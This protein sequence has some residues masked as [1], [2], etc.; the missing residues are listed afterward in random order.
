MLRGTNQEFGRPYNRRIV[1]ETIRLKGPVSRADIAREVSLSAQT[2]SNIIRELEDGGF[3]KSRR[4]KPT[5]R[6]QP[7]TMLEIDG[8]GGYAI[9]LQL[10]P[11]HAGAIAVDLAGERVA[12]VE[13]RMPSDTQGVLSTAADLAGRMRAAC[14]SGRVLGLGVAMPGPFD[15]EPMSHA[16]STTIEALRGVPLRQTFAGLTGLPVFIG[17]D[18][19]AAA[20]GERQFGAGAG[21]SD[22]FYVFFSAGLGGATISDRALWSGSHGNAGELG[23]MMAVPDGD[24]CP[25][26]ARGCLERYVSLDALRRRFQAQGL[27]PEGVPFCGDG[28]GPLHPVVEAWIADAAP[29]LARA[30]AA[31]E[32]LLDPATIIVGGALPCAVLDRLL[33]AMEPLPPSV[34]QR[35]NRA[36]PRIMRS[37]LGSD[38]ALLG[39]A[40]LAFNGVLSPRFG[41]L[42]EGDAGSAPDPI[43]ARQTRAAPLL[44]TAARSA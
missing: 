17:M 4:E 8:R 2:V 29:I 28:G 27:D 23:H 12:Q 39:A 7:A 9:G 1:L 21:L 38:A 18:G 44:Q 31:V 19:G 40:V 32:N 16:G 24:P 14:G 26:G 42:F 15:V 43:V 22:F 25:C 36:L 5:R 13:T 20:L 3:L 10:T 37:A 33:G 41:L 6:G 11:G 34:A 30:V 35:R